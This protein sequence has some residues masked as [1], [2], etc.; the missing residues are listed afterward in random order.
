[1]QIVIAE[2]SLLVFCCATIWFGYALYRRRN[3]VADIAW[4]LGFV[5]ICIYL[6]LNFKTTTLAAWM[7]ALVTIWGIRLAMHI[8]LRSMGKPEDFRY[9]QWRVEW[10]ATFIWRTYLQVF[11]L[12][13]LF[14]IVIS[15]P[16]IVVGLSATPSVTGLT[17]IGF[18]MWLIGFLFDLFL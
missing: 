10:G 7:Y 14:M 3:D 4:G 2:I 9:R 15:A 1:M 6:F 8:T 12:Q 18:L 17:F 13:G 16:L 5:A 11:L